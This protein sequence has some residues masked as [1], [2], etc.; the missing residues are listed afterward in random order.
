MLPRYFL[1]R[2][3]GEQWYS[4]SFIPITLIALFFTN[5]VMFSPKRDYIVDNALYV[6]RIALPLL[7]YFVLMLLV[8]FCMGKRIGADYPKTTTIAFTAASNNI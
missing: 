2:R 5:V 6:L 3:K 7:V 1:K 8:S 4:T